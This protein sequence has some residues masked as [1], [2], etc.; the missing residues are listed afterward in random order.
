[1]NKF[2]ILMIIGVVCFGVAMIDDLRTHALNFSQFNMLGKICCV[3]VCACIGGWIVL[4][5]TKK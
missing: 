2:Q 1:M 3:G 5:L 4:V